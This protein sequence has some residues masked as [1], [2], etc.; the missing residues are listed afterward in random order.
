M[1]TSVTYSQSTSYF[2]GYNYDTR[3]VIETYPHTTDFV[4]DQAICDEFSLELIPVHC[5]MWADKRKHIAE[6]KRNNNSLIQGNEILSFLDRN[7]TMS[8]DELQSLIIAS[9]KRLSDITQ[10]G[11][12]CVQQQTIT[13]LTEHLIPAG[14]DWYPDTVPGITDGDYPNTG[15]NWNIFPNQYRPLPSVS[16]CFMDEVGYG[17]QDKVPTNTDLC[18]TTVVA[19]T[20]R[21]MA[22]IHA[23]HPFK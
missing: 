21:S 22:E 20:R 13:N 15:E 4:Y 18:D 6:Y 12:S 3:R 19:S 5:D 17:S 11:E 9:I 16:C 23:I 7:V 1:T 14:N 2:P 10:E 8:S